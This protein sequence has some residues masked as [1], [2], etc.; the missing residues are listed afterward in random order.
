MNQKAQTDLTKPSLPAEVKHAFAEL[1]HDVLDGYDAS[2][3]DPAGRLDTSSQL[4]ETF[5]LVPSDSNEERTAEAWM[6][7]HAPGVPWDNLKNCIPLSMLTERSIVI[8]LDRKGTRRDPVPVAEPITG[9]NPEGYL[10]HVKTSSIDLAKDMAAYGPIRC[11][12]YW[13]RGTSRFTG[14]GLDRDRFIDAVAA[15]SR[16][17][18]T[19]FKDIHDLPTGSK[20]QMLYLAHT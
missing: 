2:A 15:V 10:V 5:Y 7:L 11:G 20:P 17:W 14:Y 9:R 13:K 4:H 6:K 1:P 19:K 3:S 18:V 8:V 16:P 12:D